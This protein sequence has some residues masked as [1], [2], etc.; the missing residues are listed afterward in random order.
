MNPIVWSKTTKLK[1]SDNPSS[2]LPTF[3]PPYNFEFQTSEEACQV[4]PGCDCD[5][6]MVRI[7]N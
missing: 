1:A 6:D 3:V 2:N 4:F 5:L 7:K